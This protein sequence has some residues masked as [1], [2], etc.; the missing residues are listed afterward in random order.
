[1][2]FILETPASANRDAITDDPRNISG[3]IQQLETLISTTPHEHLF[4]SF[5]RRVN[6]LSNGELQELIINTKGPA[7]EKLQELYSVLKISA[8][9]EAQSLMIGEMRKIPTAEEIDIRPVVRQALCWIQEVPT[10]QSYQEYFKSNLLK[11]FAKQLHYLKSKK[12]R[13]DFCSD[14]IVQTI[15]HIQQKFFMIDPL[16]T[17]EILEFTPSD[18]MKLQGLL[19]VSLGINLQDLLTGLEIEH[20]F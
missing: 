12:S 17:K 13:E 5:P 18:R 8:L 6:H 11:D 9:R 15:L 14:A 20:S 1:M 4:C 16:K 19:A 7:A 10:D 3:L 2:V